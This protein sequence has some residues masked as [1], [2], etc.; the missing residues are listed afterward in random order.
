MQDSGMKLTVAD[1]DATQNVRVSGVWC[2]LLQY[3]MICFLL[4]PLLRVA[5]VHSLL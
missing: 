2:V 3:A 5:V 1:N 4:A